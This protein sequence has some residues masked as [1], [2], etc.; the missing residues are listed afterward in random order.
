MPRT[1][2]RSSFFI[3][4]K[5]L[6]TAQRALGA[7]SQADVIRRAVDRVVEM[8]RFWSFMKR[9]SKTVRAEDFSDI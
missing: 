2:K 7:S 9:S 8:E 3:D 6:R 4:P 5:T 1:L